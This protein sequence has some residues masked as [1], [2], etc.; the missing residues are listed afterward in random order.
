[1]SLV[2]TM[3]AHDQSGGNNTTLTRIKIVLLFQ[4]ELSD[5][6]RYGRFEASSGATT[7]GTGVSD[8]FTASTTV[9]GGPSSSNS[10]ADTWRTSGGSTLPMKVL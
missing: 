9:A 2:K 5:L 7:G 8:A 6:P 4:D 10:R 1:M 3:M